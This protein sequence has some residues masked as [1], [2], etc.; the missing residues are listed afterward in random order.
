MKIIFNNTHKLSNGKLYSILTTLFRINIPNKTYGMLSILFVNN[1]GDV[2]QTNSSLNDPA[3]E[4]IPPD[5]IVE[6][7]WGYVSVHK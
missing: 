1:N 7:L 4:P 5:S 2:A 3:N 6:N